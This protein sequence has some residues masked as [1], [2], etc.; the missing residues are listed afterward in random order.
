MP[1][2][3]RRVCLPVGRHQARRARLAQV[4]PARWRAQR[5]GAAVVRLL[6]PAAWASVFTTPSVCHPIFHPAVCTSG[7]TRPAGWGLPGRRWPLV[8]RCGRQPMQHMPGCRTIGG[9]QGHELCPAPCVDP[10]LSCPMSVKHMLHCFSCELLLSVIGSHSS[11]LPVKQMDPQQVLARP[12]R[13]R[14]ARNSAPCTQSLHSTP[15]VWEH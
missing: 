13:D 11:G 10:W 12:A 5:G 4:M 3:G 7:T 1:G 2:R 6:L 8:R 9:Q 15:A 14:H